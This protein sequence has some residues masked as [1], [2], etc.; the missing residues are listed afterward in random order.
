MNNNW[1]SIAIAAVVAIAAIAVIETLASH[2]HIPENNGLIGWL[3]VAVF[4]LI[5]TS[6]VFQEVIAAI[7]HFMELLRGR[8]RQKHAWEIRNIAILFGAAVVS[9]AIYLAFTIVI[10]NSNGPLQGRL[11]PLFL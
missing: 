8:H 7:R 4:G 11:A 5:S 1:I 6:F 2:Q 10:N 9:G 3:E